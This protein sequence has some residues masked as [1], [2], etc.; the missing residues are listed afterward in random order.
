MNSILIKIE[1]ILIN[2]KSFKKKKMDQEHDKCPICLNNIIKEKNN[3]YSLDED[4]FNNIEVIQ[5]KCNHI[6]CK[7]CLEQWL[8]KSIHG[9]CPICNNLIVQENVVINIPSERDRQ[10]E[11]VCNQTCR[12]GL[13]LI[14]ILMFLTVIICKLFI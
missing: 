13:I 7:H 4:T 3:Y 1:Q 10:E 8:Q 11:K 14:V 6:M 12:K 2:D 9:T 5:L